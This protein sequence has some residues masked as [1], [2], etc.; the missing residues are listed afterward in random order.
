VALLFTLLWLPLR[1]RRLEMLD[2]F[3]I[4]L[5]LLADA[6]GASNIP[7]A[8]SDSMSDLSIR[9]RLLERRRLICVMEVGTDVASGPLY[10]EP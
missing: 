1:C 7:L 6:D 8:A 2:F 4:F 9:L 3:G 10:I 5:R